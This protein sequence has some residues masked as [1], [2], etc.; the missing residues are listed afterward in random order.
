MNGPQ[1]R[2]QRGAALIIAM[3]ITAIATVLAADL[4]WERDLDFRRTSGLLAQDEAFQYALG[5]EGWAMRILKEDAEDNQ[6]DHP[7]EEWAMQLPPLPF[8]GGTIQGQM[9]DLQGRFNLN[10][11]RDGNGATNPEAV[12]QFRRLLQT[13]QLNPRLAG[14]LADWIDEDV[15]ANFPDGAED[16]Q[17]L[18]FDPPYRTANVPVSSVSELFYLGEMDLE[19][20]RLLRPHV[21]ALPGNPRINLNTTTPEVLLSLSEEVAP[22]DAEGVLANRPEEGY[23]DLSEAAEYL[24]EGVLAYL[25]VASRY[26][27]LRIRVDI[28]TQRFTMYSLLDRDPS[29]VVRPLRRSFNYE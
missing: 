21:A 25:G 28:G 17:Y 29:G 20:Y 23:E 12:E 2:R 15:Q 26:F 7:G 27:E 22:G 8:P 1:L 18:G 24:P 13:L 16:G 4:V 11:L 19:S 3:L 14:L 5:A 9:F 6:Y 10:T